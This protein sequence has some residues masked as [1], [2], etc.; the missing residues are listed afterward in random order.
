MNNLKE[1]TQSAF[2]DVSGQLHLPA[3]AEN[4]QIDVVWVP[5][6]QVLLTGVVVPGKR[7]S[8]WLRALPYALEESIS[9]PLDEVF[10]A[11]LNRETSGEQQGLTSVA[12]VDQLLMKNWIEALQAAGLSNAQLVADC[13]QCGWETE[14]GMNHQDQQACYLETESGY[15]IRTGQWGGMAL[16]KSWA[17]L[18]Q[19]E[20]LV[21]QLGEPRSLSLTEIKAFGLRQGR[22][23]PQSQVSRLGRYGRNLGI[24]S[25]LVLTLWVAQNW[26]LASQYDTERQ[27][28]ASATEQLFKQMFPN[29]T[30]IVNI[31]AQ[32]QTA[33]ARQQQPTA[34]IGPAA[35]ALLIE[36]PFQRAKQV[37]IEQF[38]WQNNRL[39]LL[40]KSQDSNALQQLKQQLIN[41]LQNKAKVTLNIKKMQPN[42]I[43]AEMVIDVS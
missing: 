29:V 2:F 33:L 12:V 13:F 5:T 27:Q 43:A 25:V 15:L 41:Q 9:Q 21:G 36:S 7:K 6:Q 32:T 10:I 8:D 18:P 3:G 11:V 14:S 19:F 28:L 30:R 17:S 37:K 20:P 26:L 16:P 24:L 39:L 23:Q 40:L 34:L 38:K 22:F 31:K 1:S 35:L 42:D 4:M